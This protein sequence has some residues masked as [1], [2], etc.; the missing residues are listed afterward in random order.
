METLPVEVEVTSEM[1]R[2]AQKCIAT[3]EARGLDEEGIYRKS[4]MQA[5][6]SKTTKDID[7]GK[8]ER[9][10]FS[11]ETDYDIH[12]IG[13]CLKS[14]LANSLPEPLFTF[15]KH[16][17]LILAGKISNYDE[18]SLKLQG[19]IKDLPQANQDLLKLLINH[20]SLVA[21]HSDKNMM[22]ASNVG[23]VFGPTLMRPR[24]ETVQSIMNIKYQNSIVQQLIED[25]QRIFHGTVTVSSTGGARNSATMTTR[26]FS[27]A[28]NSNFSSRASFQPRFLL[29]NRQTLFIEPGQKEAS[30]DY[31]SYRPLSFMPK[32]PQPARPPQPS[33]ITKPPPP[34][35]DPTRKPVLANRPF[36][37]MVDSNHK[38]LLPPKADLTASNSSPFKR[39][40]VHREKQ[41]LGARSSRGIQEGTEESSARDKRLQEGMDSV[42]AT[43][44]QS[45]T[46]PPQL[47]S[48]PSNNSIDGIS[49]SEGSDSNV[50]PPRTEKIKEVDNDTSKGQKA[51]AI[52]DCDG[53]NDNELCFKK[54]DVF[55]NVRNSDEPQWLYADLRGKRGLIPEN[56]IEYIV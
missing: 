44:D 53:E 51:R 9:I 34:L 46:S 30:P 36:S 29:E 5:K 8:F 26:P 18:R 10:D 25:F 21:E 2:F 16:E 17:D 39:R 1:I 43:G 52:F 38:P 35:P 32:P 12:T 33:G 49:T 24:D 13:G 41:P 27:Q 55:E 45:A 20:L 54:F 14:L 11:D 22:R 23:V 37:V 42:E 40:P 28:I 15:S 4:G 6:I 31:P 56:Y 47:E 48:S 19:I 7:K 50:L 3:I